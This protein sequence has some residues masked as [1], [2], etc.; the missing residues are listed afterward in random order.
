MI[1]GVVIVALSPFA[2]L[3]VPILNLCIKACSERGTEAVTTLLLYYF[4]ETTLLLY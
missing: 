4:T 2:L 1:A 3:L